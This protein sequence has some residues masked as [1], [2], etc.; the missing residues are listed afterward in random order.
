[1]KNANSFHQRNFPGLNTNHLFI[2]QQKTFDTTKP[3]P[4]AM[5]NRAAR[6]ESV[7]ATDGRPSHRTAQSSALR[8]FSAVDANA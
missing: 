1:M 8:H 4:V 2:S 3:R 5:A 6:T 7:T